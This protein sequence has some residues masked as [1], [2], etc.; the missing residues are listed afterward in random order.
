[1]KHKRDDCVYYK[2][3]KCAYYCPAVIP[4]KVHDIKQGYDCRENEPEMTECFMWNEG[5]M[6]NATLHSSNISSL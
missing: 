2:N 3:G 4:P 6:G 5:V 1:M